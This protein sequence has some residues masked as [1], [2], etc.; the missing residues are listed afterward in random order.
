M[1]ECPLDSFQCHDG[2]SLQCIDHASINCKDDD[3]K[4]SA[5]IIPSMCLI[6]GHSRPNKVFSIELSLW[7]LSNLPKTPRFC[8]LKMG[9]IQYSDITLTSFFYLP[10]MPLSFLYMP[11]RW[12]PERKG[13]EGEGMNWWWYNWFKQQLQLLSRAEAMWAN[14]KNLTS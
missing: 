4:S 14:S 11:L 8:G 2:I 6:P 5:L 9:K 10:W 1:R 7:N 12:P 3:L 13:G